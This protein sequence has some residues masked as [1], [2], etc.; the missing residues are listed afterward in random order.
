MHFVNF[1]L[2]ICFPVHNCPFS[3]L[4]AAN[5]LSKPVSY[6]HLDVYK[7]QEYPCLSFDQGRNNSLYLAEEMKST[8]EYR[9]LIKANDRATLL[10][11]MIGLNAYTLCLSL[12]HI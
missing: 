1:K 12:I 4:L 2:Q 11:L 7:R 10:N 5:G 9:R 8:Y 6:T 3:N